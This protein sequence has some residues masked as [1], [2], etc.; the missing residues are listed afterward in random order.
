[1]KD[2]SMKISAQ[3]GQNAEVKIQESTELGAAWDC[4]SRPARRGTNETVLVVVGF[5]CASLSV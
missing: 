4:A 5:G 1:M 2:E 3:S